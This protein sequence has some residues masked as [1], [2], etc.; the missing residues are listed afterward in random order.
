MSRQ[1]FQAPSSTAPNARNVAFCAWV[2]PRMP[3]IS[4]RSRFQSVM[5]LSSPQLAIVLPSGLTLSDCTAPRCA[6]RTRTHC[7]LSGSLSLRQATLTGLSLAFSIIPE[8]L[9]IIITIV[10]ALGAYRLAR[11]HAIVKRLQAVETLG[12]VTT[13]ATDKTGT[14]TENRMQVDRLS[15]KQLERTLLELGTLCN[16]AI[17][18]EKTGVGDPLEV[19]LLRAWM[20]M[21]CVESMSCAT[22]LPSIPRASACPS[23]MSVTGNAGS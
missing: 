5:T 16:S 8:E 23:S 14:L 12:A 17:E 22:N 3:V 7:P 2:K 11:Q 10:L 1:Q 18:G 13:I 19:A 15:P 6:S 21:R 20:W 4:R 9:P